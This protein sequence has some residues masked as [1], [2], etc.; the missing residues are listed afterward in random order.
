MVLDPN[1]RCSSPSEL[2]TRISRDLSRQKPDGSERF[3]VI[4]IGMGSMGSAACYH[5][6]RAG[7][8]VLGLEQFEIPHEHG[9]HSGQSRIIR[10]AYFEHPNYVPL[11]TAAYDNWSKLASSSGEQLFFKTGLVSFGKPDNPLI[12]GIHASAEQHNID[13]NSIS[14]EEME[15]DYPPFSIPADYAKVVEPNA[16]FLSPERAILV[17]LTQAIA[18][19][20]VVHLSERM[21]SY[22]SFKQEIEVKTNKGSY[23]C[24]KLIFTAGPWA[25]QL[26]PPLKPSLNVTRQVLAWVNPK[27]TKSFGLNNFPCWM[28]ANPIGQ[29]L[30][31]GFPIL[32]TSQFGGPHGMKVAYHHPGEITHPDQVNRSVTEEEKLFL[33]SF[34][35]E[36]I[37]NGFDT[38]ETVKTCLYT[39]TPDDHFIVDVLPENENIILA[40]GFSGHGFKFASIVGEVLADLATKGKTVHPIEFLQLDRLTSG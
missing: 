17:H 13:I 1:L 19:N 14:S 9:S 5:L 21:V 7:C 8:R 39:N 38:F 12:T 34:L 18:Q 33:S 26:L 25:D 35:K 40:A 23:L 36:F 2:K 16:G 3:D 10:K 4:I 37:P 31:Y 11:L 15:Q 24:K 6:A 29:G 28:L 27:A 22:Q 30:F 20:A 32:P